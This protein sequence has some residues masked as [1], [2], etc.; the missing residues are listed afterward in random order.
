MHTLG[1]I[2]PENETDHSPAFEKYL[3]AAREQIEPCDI[4]TAL[5]R[6][7][8]DAPDG[9]MMGILENLIAGK[10]FE[11]ADRLDFSSLF[12]DLVDRFVEDKA[13]ELESADIEKMAA[14]FDRD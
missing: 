2:N 1:N 4:F 3:R 8:I 13:I 5:S 7:D 14:D 10:P 9:G 6:G 12:E 11:T